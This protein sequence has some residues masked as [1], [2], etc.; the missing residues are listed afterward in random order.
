MGYHGTISVPLTSCHITFLGKFL[1]SAFQRSAVDVTAEIEMTLSHSYRR[2]QHYRLIILSAGCAA[3]V[4]Q[5][6]KA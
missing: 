6:L 1:V 3:R 2:Q 4:L 5:R